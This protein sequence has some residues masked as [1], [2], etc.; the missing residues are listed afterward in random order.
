MVDIEH[1]LSSLYL[2]PFPFQLSLLPLRQIPNS[3]LK[4]ILLFG[5]GKSST[6]LIDYLLKET[7]R[8]SW[9]V[10]L[11]DNNPS[12][13]RAKLGSAQNAVAVDL[14]VEDNKQRRNLIKEADIV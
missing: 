3:K 1:S 7:G 9:Q 5:A 4:N 14:N 10:T 13:A 11:A 12:A 6:A 8:L 2:L